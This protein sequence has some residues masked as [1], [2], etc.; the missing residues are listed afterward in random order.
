MY[1]LIEMKVVREIVKM[2]L[3]MFMWSIPIAV[4]FNE[5]N[6]WYLLLFF[7]SA[8]G[9]FS[10]FT[11]YEELEEVYKLKDEDNGKTK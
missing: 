4:A 10:V 3:I 11:H 1:K 9:S 7:V 6:M 8:F 2:V 5:H